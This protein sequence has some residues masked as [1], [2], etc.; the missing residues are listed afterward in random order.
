MQGSPSGEAFIQMD[1]EKSAESTAVTKNKKLM[2]VG[3]NRLYVE[4]IQCSGDEMALVLQ[5]GLPAPIS[6][7]LSSLPQSSTSVH[8]TA[9]GVLPTGFW[10]LPPPSAH[11]ADLTLLLQQRNTIPLPAAPGIYHHQAILTFSSPIPLSLY[12]SGA[13]ALRTECR[14]AQI[15]KIK[16]GALDQYGAGPF[17]QQQFGTAGVEGLM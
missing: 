13:L 11:S 2:F 17:E 8:A 9:T 12:T 5:Q 16:N 6:A 4:V 15:S 14:S 10:P 3:G 7:S 1:S